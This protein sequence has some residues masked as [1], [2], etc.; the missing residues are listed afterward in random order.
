MDESRE[1]I[2]LD[3]EDKTEYY[4]YCFCLKSLYEFSVRN[5]THA[6]SLD[7]RCS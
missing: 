3:D 2:S 1:L 4:K 7:N 5:N 6:F